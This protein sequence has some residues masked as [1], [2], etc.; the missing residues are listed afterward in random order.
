MNR[1]IANIAAV[2]FLATIGFI[3]APASA[4][5]VSIRVGYAGLDLA[6]PAGVDTLNRRIGRAVDQICSA[7]GFRPLASAVRRCKREAHASANP[8]LANAIAAA[9][10]TQLASR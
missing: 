8:Q 4:E 7:D 5:T 1:N 3:T 2:A 10:G 9:R 6:S